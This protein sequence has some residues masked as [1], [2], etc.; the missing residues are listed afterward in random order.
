MAV[1]NTSDDRIP[2]QHFNRI[3]STCVPQKEQRFVSVDDRKLFLLHIYKDQRVSYNGIPLAHLATLFS[4]DVDKNGYFDLNSFLS[5]QA[6][7]NSIPPSAAQSPNPVS[8][9]QSYFTW[10]MYSEMQKQEFGVDGFADWIVKLIKNDKPPIHLPR[11]GDELFMHATTLKR[12]FEL[13][14]IQNCLGYDL[15]EFSDV[16]YQT[17][18]ELGLYSEEALK[19]SSFVPLTVIHQF[20]VDF[21]IGFC[22]SLFDCG[23]PLHLTPENE[24]AESMDDVLQQASQTSPPHTP[25]QS[26]HRSPEAL[27]RV[28]YSRGD[29]AYDE[30]SLPGQISFHP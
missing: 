14:D 29:A 24:A 7:L 10:L 13:F 5:F 18:I 19:H 11:C 20:A 28:A 9:I 2:I 1:P 8:G 30:L 25:P 17:G 26:P 27:S 3:Y 22:N 21:G 12:I 15:Q 6:L 16:L 4:L 23:V